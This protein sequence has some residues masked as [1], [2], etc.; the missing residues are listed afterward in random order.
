MITASI[1]LPILQDGSRRKDAGNAALDQL[2]RRRWFEL[3]TQGHLVPQLQKFGQI[4]F[5]GV[6]R[7][8]GHRHVVTLGQGDPKKGRSPLGI[9][10]EHLVKI[11]QSKK[12][13]SVILKALAGLAVLLHHGGLL[14]FFAHEQ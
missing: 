9:P 13:Q 2:S 4:T 3:I 7:N 1:Q 8:S 12:Q 5:R 10:F 11:A 14:S 6:G